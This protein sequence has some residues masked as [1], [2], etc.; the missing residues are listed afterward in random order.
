MAMGKAK[1]SPGTPAF[2]SP[3]Q[4]RGDLAEL[5][6]RSDVYNLGATLYCLLTGKA[7]VEGTDIGAVLKAVPKCEIVAPRSLDPTI[8]VALEVICLEE[9][10]LKAE[11]RYPTCRAL[12]DDVERWAADEP[13]SAQ[14]DPLVIRL[15]GWSRRNKTAV[16]VGV[17]LMVAG[18]AGLAINSVL[19]VARR[20]GRGQFPARKPGRRRHVYPGGREV[21]LAGTTDGAAP[22][23][24]PPQGT[25][26]L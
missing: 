5:G 13:V 10:S 25:G 3:E 12:A 21:A 2:M 6:P 18:I 9:I 8:D 26:L 7:P 23:R 15:G 24:I 17:A 16:A 20:R 4:A 1:Y 14:R 11:G 22:A 19:V